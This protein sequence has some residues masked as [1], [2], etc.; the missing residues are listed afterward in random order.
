M[1]AY[2]VGHYSIHNI[3]IYIKYIQNVRMTI[4][5]FKGKTLFADHEHCVL[6]GTP[7]Q[8]VVAVEF[9]SKEIA[10]QWYNSEQYQSIVHYRK[11]STTG[12]VTICT[13]I[14]VNGGVN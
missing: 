7:M 12:W 5:A 6:E 3:D 14:P 1:S 8:I 11:E 2:V 9:E 4:E 13:S 10:L